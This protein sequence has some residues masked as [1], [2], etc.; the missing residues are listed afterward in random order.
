M[1]VHVTRSPVYM[2]SQSSL[3]LVATAS[4]SLIWKP[5]LYS[6]PLPIPSRPSRQE[7]LPA[8][9]VHSP[10]CTAS[11]VLTWPFTLCVSFF[12]YQ[13]ICLPNWI[14]NS[15]NARLISGISRSPL[16]EPWW[17]LI[18]SLTP[19][20]TFLPPYPPIPTTCP[21]LSWWNE[22]T[23]TRRQNTAEFDPP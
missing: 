4:E 1:V 8:L 18:A 11:F 9:P 10:R 21:F 7:A 20:P 12:P 19:L 5:L 23:P 3:S 22:A 14:W 13:R 2:L 6:S 15:L 16:E 17:E